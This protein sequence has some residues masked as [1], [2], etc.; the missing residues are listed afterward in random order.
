[1]YAALAADNAIAL[2]P[3]LLEPI[4]A[5]LGIFQ[6]DG[7]HPTAAAQPRLLDNVWRV[8]AP[9]LEGE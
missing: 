2:L 9:M 1:M 3:F 8:L 4:A 6:P 5:D 7:L